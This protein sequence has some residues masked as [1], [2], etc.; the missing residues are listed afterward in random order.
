MERGPYPTDGAHGDFL[1]PVLAACCCCPY[2]TACT[3]PPV[4]LQ[5]LVLRCQLHPAAVP[6]LARLPHLAELD[7]NLPRDRVMDTWLSSGTA[8]SAGLMPLL[9]GAPS[10][11]TVNIAFMCR[12]TPS[13]DDYEAPEYA[14][15]DGVLWVR[16]QLQRLG[17]DP[18]MITMQT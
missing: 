2:T 14:L 9:L 1:P 7:L 5:K 11:K 15:L 12:T 13:D 17:R 16:A 3:A 10:L 18:R 8:V 6:L 4:P